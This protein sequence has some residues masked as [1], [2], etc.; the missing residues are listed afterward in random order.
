[1]EEQILLGK[2]TEKK[3]DDLLNKASD[4]DNPGRR[5]DFLSHFFLKT[6]YRASTLIGDIKTQEVFVINL[7]GVDCFTFLDYIEAMR[8]SKSFAEFKVNL[9][10]TRY[11][12]GEITF[13]TRNHFFT[14][15]SA[16]RSDFV[17]DVTKYV[18]ERKSR[19]VSKR[20][21]EK[22]DGTYFVSGVS[23][24]LREVVYLPT[25]YVDERVVEKLETGDYIGIYSNME[26][27]DVSH[28]GI[29]IKDAAAVCFRHASSEKKNRKVVD[30]DFRNYLLHKAGIIVVR[31][32]D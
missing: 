23:C 8:L 7:E 32:R 18:S 1:M 14:D 30:E 19:A 20:L 15:W 9:K 3:I 22:K 27:L 25:A 4:I 13:E 10:K 5:I 17:G 12:S 21:N 2:W 24:R 11:R 6:K 29:L 26:G 28:V 31:P 16:F